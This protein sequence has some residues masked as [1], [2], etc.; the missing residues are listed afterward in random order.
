MADIKNVYQVA[1]VMGNA[2]AM[3]KKH[4]FQAVTN[5]LRVF[6]SQFSF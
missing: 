2:P 1:E 5:A 4:Y 3:V 6:S